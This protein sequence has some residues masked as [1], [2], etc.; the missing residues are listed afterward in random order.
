MLTIG[1]LAKQVG[2]RTST[3]RFYEQEGLLQPNGR[4]EAGYRLYDAT[5][6]DRVRLIQRAQRLGFSLADIRPLLHAWES[7][8]STATAL[9][10]TAQHRFLEL[11]KQITRQLVLQHEL[12]LFLQDIGSHTPPNDAFNQLLDRI[13]AS[14]ANRFSATA[15]LDWLL[16]Q[17]DCV[18]TSDAGQTILAQLRGQHVHIW[19]EEDAYFILVVSSDT[20][21]AQALQSLAQLEANCQAHPTSPHLTY[22]DEGYLL[23]VRG[24]NAFIYARL[25]LTLEQT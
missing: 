22:G 9:Q 19:Q 23:T 13:C 16:T 6:V 24:D 2:V 15:S 21:V 1:Q 8:D 11:E 7:G 10:Q 25:F 3:L 14:P 12:G 5:A 18:L 17:A 20:A 4:T